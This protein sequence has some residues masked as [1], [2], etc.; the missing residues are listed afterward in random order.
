MTRP[1]QYDTIYDNPDL[2]T[3]VIACSNGD[4][5]LATKGYDTIGELP[6]YPRVGGAPFA[7]WN[8]PDCGSCW[9]LTYKG[10]NLTVMAIDRS[11]GWNLSLQA[12][13]DLTD[14]H[15]EELGKVQATYTRVANSECG[16]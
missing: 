3:S 2:S 4:N 11:Y 5:G 7:G 15:A 12:M 9:R 16:L 13:N 10:R 8:S 14:G 6:S 1:L